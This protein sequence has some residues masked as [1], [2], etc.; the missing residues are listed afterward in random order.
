MKEPILL[1]LFK[2]QSLLF[3]SEDQAAVKPDSF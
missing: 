2:N 3:C 1:V